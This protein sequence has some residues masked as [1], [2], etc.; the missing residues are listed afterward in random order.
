M[1]VLK[2]CNLELGSVIE[3]LNAVW[4]QQGGKL[5]FWACKKAAEE[6]RRTASRRL[7]PW[8]DSIPK[9]SEP[10]QKPPPNHQALLTIEDLLS[11]S[12][13]DLEKVREAFP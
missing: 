11:P 12:I 8:L 2:C 13:L 7:K 6:A 4:H 1:G 10:K 3:A 5:V 9:S